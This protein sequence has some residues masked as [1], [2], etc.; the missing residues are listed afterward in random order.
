MADFYYHACGKNKDIVSVV[1]SGKLDAFH[2]DYLLN[3]VEH[4]IEGGH[5]KLIL[6]CSELNFISSKGLG[7]LVR[8]HAR[9]KKHGGD[10]K[11]AGV[12]GAAASLI[13]VVHLNKAFEMYPTVEEAIAAHGG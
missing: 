3:C 11:L 12:R 6:D 9:M 7:M 4:Q 2:C 1:V 13:S 8:V 10:V 5:K